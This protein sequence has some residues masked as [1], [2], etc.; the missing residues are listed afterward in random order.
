MCVVFQLHV[1]FIF[2]PQ[3]HPVCLV[4]ISVELVHQPST[5]AAAS[6]RARSE[7]TSAKKAAA[8]TAPTPAASRMAGRRC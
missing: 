5:A 2:A 8:A 6:R 7:A 3:I 4:A 1:S